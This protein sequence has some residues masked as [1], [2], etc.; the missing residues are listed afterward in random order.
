[1]VA[2]A[3][4]AD[5]VVDAVDLLD[6]SFH[7]LATV[8]ENDVQKIK[9]PGRDEDFVA[10]VEGSKPLKENTAEDM[11]SNSA[12]S[13]HNN[14]KDDKAELEEIRRDIQQGLEPDLVVTD[15]CSKR[16]SVT[17]LQNGELSL[18]TEPQPK[19]F[20]SPKDFEL[21]KVIGMGAFG[22]V[23][24]VRNRTSGQ[25]LA[26]K[27]ISKRLL[28]R[29]SG[30]VE[31]IR[32]ER[33]ILTRVR[34][35]FVVMMHVSFQSKFKLFIVMDFLAGGELFLRL[36]REGIFLEKTAAF[37]LAEIILALEFLH[38]LGVLHRD[39]KPENILL[40][41]DGHVC[42]TDFGLAKDF[43][44]EG[45]FQN[46][47]HEARASTICGTIEYMAPEMVA[48]KGYGRA[49][50]Y[51]SL[52]CIAYEMLNGLPPFRSKMGSKDLFRKIMSEK[53]KMPDGASAAA[54]KLLKGLLHRTPHS[55]LGAARSTMFEV[56]G[57]AGLKKVDF[58]K[59]IDW[60]KLERKEVEPPERLTVQNDQDLQHFHDEFTTMPLPRSVVVETHDSFVARRIE[61][62]NFR[63]F[64]FIQ[65]DFM[66]PE[67]DQQELENYWN[68]ADE[69]G[70]SESECASSKMGS[71]DGKPQ[72]P[73]VPIEPEK[74][75]RPPRKRKKKNK[76]AETAA[77]IAGAGSDLALSVKSEESD[78][79]PKQQ[80]ASTPV[81]G[82][83]TTPPK[84][85]TVA[86]KVSP[87]NAKP[88]T[89]QK[90]KTLHA[91]PAHPPKVDARQAAKAGP[92]GTTPKAQPL[93]QQPTRQ[94]PGRGQPKQPQRNPQQPWGQQQQPYSL[95]RSRNLKYAPPQ[96]RGLAPTQ[97]SLEGAGP[98]YS[99][100][101]GVQ[102]KKGWTV[103][104]QPTATPPAPRGWANQST[105]NRPSPQTQSTPTRPTG[106][107]P[108]TPRGPAPGS[109]AAKISSQKPPT[110]A[111]KI[112]EPPPP[113][114]P[115]TTRQ[116]IVDVP[117]SPSSDWRSHTMS[118]SPRKAKT[119]ENWPGLSDF[120]AP[121]TLKPTTP[122]KAM[123]PLQGA[124]ASRK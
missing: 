117:P 47:D 32:A 28:K 99:Q 93:Q 14:N 116:A 57:P 60:E 22:K 9:S 113:P 1:M 8:E 39:L 87:Q 19:R 67:R 21:L 31:N 35:P 66:L 56:G 102:Q 63:G 27:V 40:G 76:V 68:S 84:A 45:G 104:A 29:K 111:A 16:T 103:V 11:L 105:P 38:N 72:E 97:G 51:W 33:N 73:I 75:K 118:P 115:M 36:G 88:A 42:L 61:S 86:A 65:E 85:E 55:R 3:K 98:H 121:P 34:H 44:G 100:Q 25:I 114:S 112:M 122:S 49:A 64:S 23:L 4:T 71:D 91:A 43:S 12:R 110:R 123:K 119:A 24:Q 92:P 69:E 20:T 10:F 15:T 6:A 41:E 106:P 74:K 70:E 96:R 95:D 120:P 62:D 7:N 53:V 81:N 58:F 2:A 26:M 52:G 37:Y 108:T 54:C 82:A 18:P 78:V 30:Y 94:Q 109:W 90:S 59:T 101:H 50:D 48:R 77:N 83:I 124:W 79:T 107:N 13:L 46:D 17:S 89:T 5:T 80:H